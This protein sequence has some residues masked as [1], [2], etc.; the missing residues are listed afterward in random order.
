MKWVVRGDLFIGVEVKPAFPLGVPGNGQALQPATGELDQ[1]L[2]QGFDTKG[3]L[4][5]EVAQPPICALRTNEELAVLF[6]EARLDTEVGEG[7][8]VKISQDGLIRSDLHRPF[9]VGPQ[10]FYIL[11]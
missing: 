7:S 10:P 11:F 2:L 8:I 5:L 4:D 1:V 6:V 9:M 3:I